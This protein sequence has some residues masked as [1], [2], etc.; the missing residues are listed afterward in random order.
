MAAVTNARGPMPAD[1]LPPSLPAPPTPPPTPVSTTP[2]SLPGVTNEANLSR[3][4]AK[5]K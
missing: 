4:L 3:G 1:P 5:R 2:T